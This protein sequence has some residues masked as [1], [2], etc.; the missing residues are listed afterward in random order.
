MSKRLRTAVL[1]SGRG[2]N[3]E[4]LLDAAEDT[5]YAADIVLVISNR[6]EAA[7]LNKADARGIKAICIDHRDFETREDFEAELHAALMAYDIEFIA[8]AGFM[9]V[10]TEKFVRL[11]D[12]KMIN[13]HPSLLPKYKGLHTHKRALEAGDK[14]H[15]CTVHWVAPEVDGGDIIAQKKLRIQ[16]SD[17]PETLAKR[18]LPLE[19]D[20]Y[21]LSLNKAILQILRV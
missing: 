21:K 13:I 17:T 12:R 5:S 15:G 20:L 1:I 2:S 19:L 6:P 18:L 9:R 4:A 10:L 8:C 3:M 16:L 14:E 7:G 11:W